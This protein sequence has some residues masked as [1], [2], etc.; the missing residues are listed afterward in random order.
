MAGVNP[1][2]GHFLG[3]LAARPR[4]LELVD[5][6]VEFLLHALLHLQAAKPVLAHF[7]HRLCDVDG[8]VLGGPH[9]RALH[10]VRIRAQHHEQVREAVDGQTLV[11]TRL[12]LPVL[13][14]AATVRAVQDGVDG[15]LGHRIAGAEDDGVDRKFRAVIGNDALRRDALQSLENDPHIGLGQC[16]IPVIGKQRPLASQRVVRCEAAA[17]LRVLDRTMDVPDAERMRESTQ[18]GLI[19][20]DR[21]RWFQ[22]HEA[23]LAHQ[24][25]QRRDAVEQGAHGLGHGEI[26]LG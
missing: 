18:Q 4:S 1:A 7:T 26:R 14:Q 15:R 24:S 13:A 20:E 21:Q 16:V 3:F 6:R 11:G 5:A 8:L 10:A 25:L 12:P 2:D 23:R 19:H 9:H 17:H 22:A